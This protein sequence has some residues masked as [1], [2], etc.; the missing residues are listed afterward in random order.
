MEMKN[1]I[2]AKQ[3]E[4]HSSL[5]KVKQLIRL[6]QGINLSKSINSEGSSAAISNGTD[7]T[8]NVTAAASAPASSSS[9]SQSCM[10]NCKKG[11]ETK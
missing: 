1:T 10:V 7:S 4:M 2:L 6:I 9:S 11:S 3:K 8:S 5:E